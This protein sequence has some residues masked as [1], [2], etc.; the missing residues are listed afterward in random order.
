MSVVG[1]VGLGRAGR[2]GEIRR[3]HAAGRFR[4]VRNRA[5]LV[6]LACLP[7]SGAGADIPFLFYQHPGG[8]D[9]FTG[10]DPYF[11]WQFDASGNF[12]FA[13]VPSAG[14]D[15][16][17]GQ[18]GTNG[19]SNGVVTLNY[20]YPGLN[21]LDELVVS[22]GNTVVQNSASSRMVTFYEFIVGGAHYTQNDGTHIIASNGS[23]NQLLL[24]S[25]GNDVGTYTLN[26]GVFDTS[27]ISAES[28]GSDGTGNFI[29]TGGTH[30]ASWIQLGGSIGGYQG[31]V[32]FYTLNAGTLGVVKLDVGEGLQGVG[33][34]SQYGGRN[35]VGTLNIGLAPGTSGTVA[36][37]DI[38][39]AYASSAGTYALYSG[40]LHVTGDAIVGNSGRGSLVFAAPGGGNAQID[41]TL[42]IAKNP[43]STGTVELDAG[44]LTAAAISM[45]TDGATFNQSASANFFFGA[46]TQMA[47]NANIGLGTN[48]ADLVLDNTVSATPSYNLTGGS[49]KVLGST[50]VGS[51][52]AGTINATFNQSGGNHTIGQNL[53][54]GHQAGAVGSYNMVGGTLHVIGDAIIGNAGSGSLFLPLTGAFV[55]NV[56][57]DGTLYIANYPGS[58]GT[59][60][61]AAGSLAAATITLAN[62]GATFNQSASGAL[63]FG[64]FKQMA[65]SVNIGSGTSPVDLVLSNFLS[66]TPSYNLSGGSLTVLG[67]T[68]VG[69][70]IALAVNAT[71]NQLAGTHA[72]NQNLYL[73]DRAADV[74]QY[75]L[76]GG[77]LSV[78]GNTYVGSN[79]TGIFTQNGGTHV[80]WDSYPNGVFLGYTNTASGIYNLTAGAL[81]LPNAEMY[82][83]YYG[84]GIYDQSGGSASARYFTTGYYAPGG[85]GTANLSGGTLDVSRGTYVGYGG[86]GVFNQTGGTHTT[87]ALY[88]GSLANGGT[89]TPGTGSYSLSNAASVL[90]VTTDEVVGDAG[91]GT[92][93]QTGGLHTAGTL[94]V[95]NAANST[96]HFNLSAATGPSTLAVAGDEYVGID[97][98][99]ASFTQ[100]GGTHTIGSGTNARSLYLGY[101]S[102]GSGLF[103]LSGGS[104]STTANQYIGFSGFGTYNQ[105]G[106][107]NEVNG[108]GTPAGLFFGYNA[109][110]AGTGTLS[111]GPSRPLTKNTSATSAKASS[112]S[113]ADPTP[114]STSRWAGSPPAT[115]LTPSPADR[116]PR[117]RAAPTLAS[118][119]TASSTSPP[120]RTS[121]PTFTSAPWPAAPGPTT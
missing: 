99:A 96:G 83:G 55:Q 14:T 60:D 102:A 46:F 76:S 32:G 49:L 27:A 5:G 42:Y 112:P 54:V 45:N 28:L 79:G 23:G 13:D 9:W 41:G 36:G 2:V 118:T 71:F 43:G 65:G 88:I 107:T 66:F 64:A 19:I 121:P 85:S 103:T 34:F 58:S 50:Y 39:Y 56:Q 33:L 11:G 51:S 52:W 47:G 81:T 63:F 91:F 1:P 29:Q 105:S 61:L 111:A 93:T 78:I 80:I 38:M 98:V 22:D 106:G 48:P 67:N 70:S 108:T 89:N 116:S 53:Y 75:N 25:E 12:D 94:I 20:A 6:L 72:V 115:V 3:Q 113:L 62:P 114:P 69:S 44:S 18:L 31:G 40:T 92:F 10:A 82:V 109:A 119:A 8:G 35:T 15:V 37:T 24:L 7:G 4:A 84:K 110:S 117:P 30:N 87:D 26:G 57:I 97:S 59:V 74:G 21:G 90:H 100:S 86:I 101:G 73:G 16:Y 120:A 17:V 104:L 95:G 68:F 77:T